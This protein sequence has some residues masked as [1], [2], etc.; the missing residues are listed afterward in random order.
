MA[1]DEQTQSRTLSD[2]VDISDH[3]KR[4]VEGFDKDIQDGELPLEIYNNEELYELELERVFAR[5]W[6]F[7]GHESEIPDPGDYWLRYIGED[8]FILVRDES[9]TIRLLFDSCR[10]RGTKLCRTE[11]GNTSH[12]R[13]PYHGWTY[14]NTG[15]L[16]GVSQQSK[17]FKDIDKSEYS[18]HEAPNVETYGGFIF[19]SLNEN[20]PPLEEYFDDAKWYL[21]PHFKITEWEVVGEPHRWQVNIDWKT[22][23]ENTTTDNYHVPIGHK[24]AT[25][26][27]IGPTQGLDATVGG[28]QTSLLAGIAGNLSHSIYRVNSDE[29]VYWGHPEEIVQEF[30][31]EQFSSEQWENIVRPAVISLCNVFPN[32]AVNHT[33][34]TNDPDKEAV[35]V[36]Y[37]RQYQPKGPGKIEIWAWFLAPK[38]ASTSYKERVHEVASGAFSSSGNFFV[39]DLSILRGIAESGGSTF[40]KQQGARSV[41]MDNYE[42]DA[43]EL[44]DWAGPGTIYDKGVFTNENNL[45]F[46]QEWHKMICDG[47]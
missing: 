44:P 45:N 21:D 24:S 38:H 35:G 39:D 26:I 32:L 1:V 42:S 12:F 41:Y 40:A 3:T 46:Y 29:D 36:L 28:D 19:A 15:E 23:T 25:D 47:N 20:A 30:R 27:G 16:V 17:V 2:S 9:G 22:V 10:H 18:L 31:D 5:S 37:L 13:C 14:K 11:K 43:E 4:L 7:V 8:P 6:V 34:A 33:L